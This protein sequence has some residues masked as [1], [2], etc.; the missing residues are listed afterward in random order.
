ML[1]DRKATY[2]SLGHHEDTLVNHRLTW[3]LASQ[4]LLFAGF[5][6][7]VVAEGVAIEAK[8]KLLWTLAFIG[9]TSSCIILIGL[10]GAIIA[11]VH[12]WCDANKEIEQSNQRL[13]LGVRWWT[14]LMGWCPPVVLPLIFVIA[15]VILFLGLN[16]LAANSVSDEKKPA[17]TIA[18]DDDT[19]TSSIRIQYN[20]NLDGLSDFERRVDALGN[21]DPQE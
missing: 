2:D 13:R 19:N 17:T 1:R 12:L 20:G 9:I 5:G 18:I 10:L 21:Q 8:Q 7:I 11:S 16:G 14:T 4:T 3:L 15:W 6:A